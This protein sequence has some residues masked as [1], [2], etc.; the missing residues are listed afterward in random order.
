MAVNYEHGGNVWAASRK[1]GIEP[2]KILDFSA[3][4]NPLG[5]PPRVIELLKEKIHHLVT[6]YPEPQA[7]SLAQAVAEKL[8]L[9]SECVIIGN[10]ASELI[11]LF[12]L[13]LRPRKVLIPAPTYG[14]YARAARSVGA[15][16]INLVPEE[17]IGPAPGKRPK[18]AEIAHPTPE[19]MWGSQLELV[20]G[21]VE[22]L[23]PEALV[24]CNPNNPTGVFQEDVSPLLE[25]KTPCLLDTSFLPFAIPNWMDWLKNNFSRLRSDEAPLFIVCSLTKIFALPGLR[26]GFGLGPPDL[27]KKMELARDP[28]SVNSLAIEAGMA[29]WEETEYLKR[30]FELVRRERDYLIRSLAELPGLNPFPSRANFLLVNCRKTGRTAAEIAEAAAA[31]RCL[32]RNADNFAG[33]DKYY[34]RLAVKKRKENRLLLEILKE[35]IGRKVPRE[36]RI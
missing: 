19:D 15:G 11:S 16:T 2:Q 13:I 20:K 5:P 25:I 6:L 10:G 35:V 9:P 21:E 1:L 4:I 33:L 12:F 24:I 17:K 29:C 31:K 23:H 8:D 22:R 36:E 34:L 27:V 18:T 30:S 14:D 3:N 32:L 7:Y 28:W 26:L